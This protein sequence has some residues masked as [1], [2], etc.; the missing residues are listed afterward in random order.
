MPARRGWMDDV[1]RLCE[2][3]RGLCPRDCI[4]WA[5]EG[6][7]RTVSDVGAIGHAG[8]VRLTRPGSHANAGRRGRRPLRTGAE[9]SLRHRG[10]Q[11]CK[12]LK[13]PPTP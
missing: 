13:L 8:R 6:G 3:V 10:K 11:L 9:P 4:R 1:G 5:V 7:G 12:R 2:M